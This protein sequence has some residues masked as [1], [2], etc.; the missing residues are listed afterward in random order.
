VVGK[1]LG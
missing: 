1:T